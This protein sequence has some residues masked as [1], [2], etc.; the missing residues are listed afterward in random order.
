MKGL[1][2]A[3]I[4]AMG[5]G[6]RAPLNTALEL[7]HCIV[8]IATDVTD[9]HQW[10]RIACV[11][12]RSGRSQK[13]PKNACV[14][15]VVEWVLGRPYTVTRGG[16]HYS[17]RLCSDRRYSDNPQSRRPSTSLAPLGVRRNSR[18]WKNI[19]GVEVLHASKAKHG[20]DG[21]TEAI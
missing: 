17:D 10:R 8:N 11:A 13:S 14:S 2:G 6:G 19:V 9:N 4:G 3:T 18:N 12:S 1:K 20:I 16:R 5:A 15:D 7:R 21:G